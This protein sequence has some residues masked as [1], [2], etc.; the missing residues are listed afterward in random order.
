MPTP[1]QSPTDGEGLTRDEVALLGGGGDHRAGHPVRPAAA[2]LGQH[3]RLLGHEG[4]GV[5]DQRVAR[6]VL[7][8]AAAL[9]AL[10]R[11]TARHD[12]HVPELPGHAVGAAQDLAVEQHGPADAGA[13]RDHQGRGRTSGGAVARLGAGGAVGVVVEQHRAAEAGLEQV[14]QRLALPRAGGG[15]TSPARRAGRRSRPPRCRRRPAASRQR[16]RGSPRPSRPR[17]GWSRPGGRASSAARSTT[18]VPSAS[19]TPASTLVPPM[20]TPT[21]TSSFIW[22]ILAD[23]AGSRPNRPPV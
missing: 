18:P 2:H 22:S 16:T 13:H 11:L 5:A 21:T 20:S 10:A 4:P 19:T 12:L 3:R 15:R 8:P 23:A 6:R 7:L 1:S 17:P 9:P 14:A